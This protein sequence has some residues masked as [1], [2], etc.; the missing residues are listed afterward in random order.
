MR[1]FS[2]MAR[3]YQHAG[4]VE[5]AQCDTNPEAI[6]AAAR[7]QRVLFKIKPGG[8]KVFVPKFEHVY[9]V[10]NKVRP[11]RTRTTKDRG[12]LIRR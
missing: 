3:Q 4:E 2:I 11:L 5:V 12:H 6:A 7:Q 10:D 8:R 9:V 1:R